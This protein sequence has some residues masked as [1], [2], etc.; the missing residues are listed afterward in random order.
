MPII[1][2]SAFGIIFDRPGQRMGA[3]KLPLLIVNEDN[4]PFTLELVDD[5][6]TSNSLEA[7]IADRSSAEEQI[8]TRRFGVAVVFPLGFGQSVMHTEERPKVQLMHNPL[9][10]VEGQWAEG[11]LTEV[12]M[13]RLARKKLASLGM[14]PDAQLE[15]PF[16]LTRIVVP[17][18][19]VHPFNSY[20][21]SFCGM[22][23]QYLLFWGME[24]GLLL[25]RERQRGLWD[26]LRARP[27][28]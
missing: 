14:S 17:A 25:L 6:L 20:T 13:K 23:L 9:S 27:C 8:E 15:R 10:A 4:S 7:R 5:L 11:V 16:G 2:A 24:S 28:R 26:R 19:A 3:T 21:H 12:V 22:T 18:E 1:L